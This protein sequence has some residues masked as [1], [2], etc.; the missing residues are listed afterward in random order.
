M[1]GLLDIGPLT[2][3]I[4]VRGKELE[5]KGISAKGL[6]LLL[7]EFPEMRKL[8]SGSGVEAKPEQL[9]HQIPGAVA[10]IIAAATGHP[11]DAMHIKFAAEELNLGEQAEI[12]QTAWDLTFP[13]GAQSFIEALG[14][15]G[16]VTASGWGQV[17]ASPE[18]SK[19]ASPPATQ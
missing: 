17:T 3:I 5:V 2:R 6:F 18:P 7:D 10:S 19:N 11:G 9:I 16:A 15:V 8:L 13:K 12:I 14:A 1:V 4:T